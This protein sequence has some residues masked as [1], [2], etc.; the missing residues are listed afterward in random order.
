MQFLWWLKNASIVFL[1]TN[2]EELYILLL[3]FMSYSEKHFKTHTSLPKC[4]CSIASL[5][6][7]S[8]RK[9][10]RKSYILNIFSIFHWKTPEANSIPK[11]NQLRED[12]PVWVFI[13]NDLLVLSSTSC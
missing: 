6:I 11:N 10:P 7:T 1:K 4:S 3:K 12:N 8:S 5:I 13:V 9:T 2:H